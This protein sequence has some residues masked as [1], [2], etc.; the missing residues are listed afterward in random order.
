[1][2]TIEKMLENEKYIGT[3]TLLDSA[4]QEY[5]YQM[6]EVHPQLISDEKLPESQIRKEKAQ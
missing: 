2:R 5:Y 4:T 1:M 6:K 3:V